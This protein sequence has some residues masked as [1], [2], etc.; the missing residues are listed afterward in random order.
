MNSRL[1]TERL[2]G[3]VLYLFMTFRVPVKTMDDD[4]KAKAK[5]TA[6]NED[7][8][9]LHQYVGGVISNPITSD[10]PDE[11]E[12]KGGSGTSSRTENSTSYAGT[13]SK[14]TSDTTKKPG[15]SS[16]GTTSKT[17]ADTR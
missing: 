14:E 9:T 11:A 1:Y 6:G 17:Q 10:T 7:R 16:T 8:E 5:R 15:G 13:T 4:E 3:A 12:R 2:K